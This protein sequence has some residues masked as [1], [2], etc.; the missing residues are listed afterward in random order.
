MGPVFANDAALPEYIVN[1]IVVH[2]VSI[3]VLLT[4]PTQ[5]IVRK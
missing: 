4:Y 1:T 5:M 2:T 3:M